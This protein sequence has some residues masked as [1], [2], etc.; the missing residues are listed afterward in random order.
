MGN[1]IFELWVWARVG[2]LELLGFGFLLLVCYTGFGYGI[3][4]LDGPAFWGIR[5][6]LLQTRDIK[7][8]PGIGII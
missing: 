8:G 2:L 4:T 1:L 3:D 5:E 7:I 6:L